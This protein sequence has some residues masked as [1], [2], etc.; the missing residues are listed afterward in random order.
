MPT[1]ALGVARAKISRALGLRSVDVAFEVGAEVTRGKEA[2]PT[3]DTRARRKI[4]RKTMSQVISRSEGSRVQLEAFPGLVEFI[5]ALIYTNAS[6]AMEAIFLAEWIRFCS[7]R[8]GQK[9][10]AVGFRMVLGHP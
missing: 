3:S 4:L 6:S 10:E 5:V 8:Y 1:G 9:R 2:R 7:A